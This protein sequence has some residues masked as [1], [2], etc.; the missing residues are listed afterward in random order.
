MLNVTLICVGKMREKHYIAA[1]QEYEK[2]LGAFCRFSLIELPEQRLP[3][4]PAQKEIDAALE[5]EAQ[6]ILDHVPKGAALVAMC[7]EGTEL[8]SETL[9][10]RLTLWQ[11]GGTSRLCFVVGGSFGLHD[12]V[13]RAAQL[14]LSMSRMTFPHH[15]ARVMLMEQIYRACTINA[16]TQYHK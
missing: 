2:R 3:E 14:K 1:F 7:V 4:R 5:K 8:S 10:E 11:N 9:A 12:T 16:G 6:S 13:K 15:L